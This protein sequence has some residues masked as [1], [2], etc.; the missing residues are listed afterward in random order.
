MNKNLH[1]EDTIIEIGKAIPFSQYC[2]F[3]ED[4]TGNPLSGWEFQPWL[5]TQAGKT[6]KEAASAYCQAAERKSTEELL[7]EDRFTIISDADKALIRAFNSEMEALGYDFDGGIGDGY[8]WGRYMI[9]Y[10]KTGT[11]SKK[12]IARIYIR[13]QPLFKVIFAQYL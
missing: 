12:G 4:T 8:R 11:K 3:F 9:L 5:N 13:E 1:T 7:S 6:L 10:T 2:A